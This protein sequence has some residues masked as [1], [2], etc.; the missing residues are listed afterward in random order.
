MTKKQRIIS[1]CLAHFIDRA[2]FPEYAPST[3][4]WEDFFEVESKGRASIPPERYIAIAPLLEAK[5][6]YE[7]QIK[8]IF[9]EC[10][11]WWAKGWGW[12]APL[13]EAITWAESDTDMKPY[14]EALSK[15]KQ[16]FQDSPVQAICKYTGFSEAEKNKYL[17]TFSSTSSACGRNSK[18]PDDLKA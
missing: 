11:E 13:H 1:R 3:D 2:F 16:A 9:A 14:A 5:G 10:A 18:P 17:S 15:I 4:D 7:L 8:M 12:F 6:D